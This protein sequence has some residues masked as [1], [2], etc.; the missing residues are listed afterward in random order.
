MTPQ[1]NDDAIPGWPPVEHGEERPVEMSADCSPGPAPGGQP[2][3][4]RAYDRW[5]DAHGA[6]IPVGA[7][8]RQ[9]G[10]YRDHG[11]LTSRV[12]KDGEVVGYTG[13][14][15]L[16]VR[17][18]GEDTVVTIRPFYLALAKILTLEQ[19][20]ARVRAL[21]ELID[22]KLDARVDRA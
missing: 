7:R 11:A 16:R 6:H 3:P 13:G 19:V 15:R 20:G 17:F 21:H 5:R 14:S 18:D 8:V 4:R 12:G 9:V 22:A 10:V 1:L 2:A